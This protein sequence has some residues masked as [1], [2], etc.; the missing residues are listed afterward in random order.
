MIPAFSFVDPPGK[1]SEKRMSMERIS[2]QGD[3]VSIPRAIPVS[4][5]FFLAWA[6]MPGFLAYRKGDNGKQ[7]LLFSST[8]NLCTFKASIGVV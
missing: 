8:S 3:P 2:I 1:L 4:S 5:E 7:T 6:C